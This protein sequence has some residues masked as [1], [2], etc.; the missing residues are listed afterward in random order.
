VD[1]F[2]ELWAPKFLELLPV[3]ARGV[4]YLDFVRGAAGFEAH[5]ALTNHTPVLS[6]YDYAASNDTFP[7]AR[8]LL[9][10]ADGVKL[11]LL[12]AADGVDMGDALW[13]EDT[14]RAVAV[15]ARD[16][17]DDADVVVLLTDLDRE[18]AWALAGGGAGPRGAAVRLIASARVE[19][20]RNTCLDARRDAASR[21]EMRRASRGAVTEAS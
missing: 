21:I 7:A 17:V 10:E 5:L 4:T 2:L 11:G 13:A 1:P 3:A 6:N 20:Y 12:M 15:A 14:K 9:L 16:V 8:S 18:A 19:T